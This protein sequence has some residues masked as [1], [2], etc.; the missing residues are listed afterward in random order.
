MSSKKLSIKQ[1]TTFILLG[2]GAVV[3]ILLIAAS[4]QLRSAA[5]ESQKRSLSKV[6]EVSVRQAMIELDEV[7]RDLATY[8]QKTRDFKTKIKK[9]ID[10]PGDA[11]L[12]SDVEKLLSE[13]YHQRYVTSSIVDLKKI[14]IYSLD[15]SLVAESSEGL[16]GLPFSLPHVLYKG[17]KDRQ[18]AD[19][20][21]MLSA[22][23][24]QDGYSLYS[25]LLPVGGLRQAGYMEVIL[26]PAH[27]MK[28]IEQTLQLPLIIM[29]SNGKQLYKS[30]T[31]E[32]AMSPT[33]LPIEY[34]FRN[35]DGEVV[36]HFKV[37]QDM[38]ELYDTM[39]ATQVSVLTIFGLVVSLF[40]VGAL[41]IFRSFLFT[42][43]ERLVAALSR[44][45]EGD[46]TTEIQVEG[47]EELYALSNS[48]SVL[49]EN[50]REQ[51]SVISEQA[52]SVSD[53]AVNLSGITY[54][55]QKALQ[56]QGRETEQVA[57]SVNEMSTSANEISNNARHVADSA[58]NA[59]TGAVH[60]EKVVV[61]TVNSIQQLANE[62]E[63]TASVV[64]QLKDQSVN[65]GTVVDVIKSIAEQTNLLALNAAIEA[66]RAGEQGRGFAVVADEVRTLA[67][68]TQ[69]STQE[70]QQMIEDLQTGAQNAVME[71]ENSRNMANTTVDTALEAGS[72]LESI[73]QSIVTISNMTTEIATASQQQCNVVEVINQNISNITSLADRSSNAF[74]QVTASSQKLSDS[75]T[76]M[77][78]LVN[79]FK[80]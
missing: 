25:A 10:K 77:Q 58:N 50:L 30:E 7:A 36:M 20:L 34:H 54:D 48:V 47:L 26:Q 24:E 51:V 60:G 52:H 13:Q 12:V 80:V 63:A 64:T 61:Q 22:I 35:D 69:Q 38:K 6:I 62:V 71:M 2:L 9:L 19:R 56:E 53:A 31:W 1:I 78:Q 11:Q 27:N 16:Q 67:G 49:V 33:S 65:I 72:S 5:L 21:K 8:T 40:L 75:A 37:L 70:I 74:S 41:W 73:T 17:S 44:C 55:T 45:A 14:R 46:L 15:H 18:G 43:A 32:S 4:S 68:R 42:P 57:T 59:K 3:V 23:W 79:R 39:Q 29:S 66:A 28:A 76:G